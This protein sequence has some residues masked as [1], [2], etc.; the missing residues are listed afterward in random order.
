MVMTGTRRRAG[1]LALQ[2]RQEHHERDEP[3]HCPQ[4]PF[5]RLTD[6]V[7]RQPLSKRSARCSK[8]RRELYQLAASGLE[9]ASSRQ[10]AELSG[11]LA[12]SLACVAQFR[13]VFLW[14]MHGMPEGGY[15]PVKVP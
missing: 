13:R 11:D 6:H 15:S 3:G 2:Q 5:G 14:H 8:Y 4:R 9:P 12:V 7:Y 1:D 10:L